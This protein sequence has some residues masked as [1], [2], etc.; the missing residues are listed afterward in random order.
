[1]RGLPGQVRQYPASCR[2]VAAFQDDLAPYKVNKVTIRFP[3]SKPVP[4]K[5]RAKEV[6]DDQSR[7]SHLDNANIYVIIES[8]FTFAK[9]L[10]GLNVQAAAKVAT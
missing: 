8:F 7:P 2:L 6:A 1:M 5:F 9:W 10:R 3:L 4:V